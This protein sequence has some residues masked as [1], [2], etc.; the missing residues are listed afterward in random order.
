MDRPRVFISSTIYD[1][2]D[3]RSSL[4]FWLDEF[5]YQVQSSDFNDF[6]KDIN[7][8]SYKA[9][10]A[11]VEKAQYFVLLIGSRLG[12]YYDERKKISITQ[13]EY[14]KACQVAK[15]KGLRL[16]IFIRQDLWDVKDDRKALIEYLTENY[17]KE[18][19]L[20]RE[21]LKKI[22]FHKS[23]IVSDAEFV[24]NFI[25]E[26]CKKQE[27]KEAVKKGVPFPKGNWTHR[28]STFKDIV[29]V[30]RN[31]LPLS[32]RLSQ[33]AYL[34]NVKMEIGN[35]LKEFFSREKGNLVFQGE[36]AR[37]AI[38]KISGGVT[39]N[40][41]LKGDHLRWL[42]SYL[43]LNRAANDM[44][45]EFI[46][47]ALKSGEFLEYCVKI[48]AYKASDFHEALFQLKK[49]I[50]LFRSASSYAKEHQEFILKY[51]QYRGD[52]KVPV[53]NIELLTI[54]AMFNSQV[55]ILTL[56]RYVIAHINNVKV[57]KLSDLALKPIHACRMETERISAEKVSCDDVL[58][59]CYL[60]Q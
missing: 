55:N 21:D 8:N 35:N 20:K 5:G 16:I 37:F 27:M 22:P 31:E 7:K 38:E 25:D 9:C 50:L 10:L 11:A 30:L 23:K 2:R 6:E 12:G 13:Q 28:F 42:C 17:L 60:K 43:L 36:W 14:R 54:S 32:M 59:W 52:V 39:D 57:M 26:V 40:S 19:K 41:S 29:D 46:D 18:N 24:F 49:Q 33:L 58:A 53:P 4:K 3:L 15:V 48:K 56:S 44:S 34:F 47:E 1:F 45:T 51:K